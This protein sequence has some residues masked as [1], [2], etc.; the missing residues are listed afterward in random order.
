MTRKYVALVV[1]I[2]EVVEE[3][4]V[5]LIGDVQ[6]KCFVNYCSS[7]IEVGKQY[8]IELEMMLPDKGFVIAAEEKSRAIEMIGG[9]FSCVLSGYLNGSV[10]RSFVDFD[11]QGIHYDYPELN[12]QYVKIAVDRIDVSFD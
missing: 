11:D 9:G 2:D 3:E 12:E 10:F 7:K 5:L 6:A 4:V 1:S 8:E